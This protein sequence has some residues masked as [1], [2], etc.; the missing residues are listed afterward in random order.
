MKEIVNN[1]R[2]KNHKAL[3]G[4]KRNI[5]HLNTYVIDWREWYNGL[6]IKPVLVKSYGSFYLM[7][8]VT[9]NPNSV[10]S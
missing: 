2:F 1:I 4:R 3:F 7:I 9:R 6:E 10:L 5:L 8:E